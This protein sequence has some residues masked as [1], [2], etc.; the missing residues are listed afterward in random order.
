M[1]LEKIF[2]SFMHICYYYSLKQDVI[3]KDTVH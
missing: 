1:V 3:E 2:E